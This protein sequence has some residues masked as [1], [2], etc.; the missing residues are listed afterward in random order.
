[1]PVF[2][3]QKCGAIENTATS[4]YWTNEKHIC[5]ECETG[6]WHERF[7]KAQGL[8]DQF[9]PICH[10]LKDSYVHNKCGGGN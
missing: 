2:I 5:S 6:R 9:C 1:M 7:K 8:P 10:I 4:S 3:C